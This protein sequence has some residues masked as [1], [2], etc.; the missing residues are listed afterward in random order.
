MRESV[1]DLFGEVP[2]YHHDIT[3]WLVAVPGIPPDSPRAAAYVRGYNVVDKIERA[4]ME[5]RFDQ[6][7]ERRIVPLHWWLRF[8]WS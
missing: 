8:N 4:K 3:A 2:V 6:V 5:G 7:I 1:T